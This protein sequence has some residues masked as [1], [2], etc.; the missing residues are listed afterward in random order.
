M[1]IMWDY[2]IYK[3]MLYINIYWNINTSIN[4][5]MFI[6][7]KYILILWVNNVNC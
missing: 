4:I 5:E 7:Y 1:R 2:Q 6:K 3:I